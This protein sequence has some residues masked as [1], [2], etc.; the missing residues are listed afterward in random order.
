MVGMP[1]S[2]TADDSRTEC[3]VWPVFIDGRMHQR[4]QA[5]DLDERQRVRKIAYHAYLSHPNS[6]QREIPLFNSLAGT[7]LSVIRM[8]EACL[9]CLISLCITAPFGVP[10]YAPDII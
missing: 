3:A 10:S 6:V 1:A 7:A 5:A 2:L 8:M 4:V 9:S